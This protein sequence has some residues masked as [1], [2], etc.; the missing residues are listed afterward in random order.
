VQ[1]QAAGEKAV[2]VS[3]LHHIVGPK[4][5]GGQSPGKR[6]RPGLDVALGVA[7]HSGLAGGAAGD[8]IAH[9]LAL[10]GAEHA[11]GVVVSQV[12]LLGEGQ[13]GDIGQ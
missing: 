13:L 8:V 9:H 12:Y 5:D 7:N 11:Y 3:H 4:A 10:G 1:P 6:L 2:A